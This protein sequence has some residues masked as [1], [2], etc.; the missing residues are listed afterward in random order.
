MFKQLKT[1][2][3]QTKFIQIIMARKKN[4]F[5]YVLRKINYILSCHCFDTAVWGGKKVEWNC[6]CLSVC[7]CVGGGGGGGVQHYTL[8]M[9]TKIKSM[10]WRCWNNF[11]F[12][13]DRPSSRTRIYLFSSF[14]V[15]PFQWFSFCRPSFFLHYFLALDC[16]S[17]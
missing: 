5:C 1:E 16:G 10:F 8:R 12:I 9:E 14:K 4:F 17:M 2:Q 6:A 7:V 13:N 11:F 15:S 3:K